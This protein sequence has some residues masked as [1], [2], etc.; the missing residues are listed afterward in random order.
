MWMSA[1]SHLSVRME[2][3]DSHWTDFH[4]I[5]C[6][7]ISQ[8]KSLEIIQVSSKSDKNN[9]YFTWRPIYIFNN[10]SL[11]CSQNE[12]CLRR[13]CGKIENAC[14]MFSNFC[15]KNYVVY[16]I[17]CKLWYRQ[18]HSEYVI[19]PAFL[20]QQRLGKCAPECHIIHTMPDLFRLMPANR[21]SLGTL[22]THN[23]WSNY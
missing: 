2:Q 5:W 19:I 18:T 4:E 13:R 9:G 3:L 12:K 20:Q 23:L 6:A 10:I 7:I 21:T 22:W 14:F 15:Q 11:N 8:K 17:M 16:E 1:S